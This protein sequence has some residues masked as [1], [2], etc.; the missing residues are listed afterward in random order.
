MPAVDYERL[1]GLY[2]ALVATDADTEFFVRRSLGAS[3]KVVELMAGTGRVALPVA[4]AGVDLTCVDGSPAMLEILRRKLSDRRL[5]ARVV[6]QDVENLDLDSR[7]SLAFIAFNSFMEITEDAARERALRRIREHLV[8][9]GSFICTLHDP[10]VRLRS[11]GPD[12]PTR[13][14]LRDPATGREIEMS[15][16]TAVENG[17]SLVLGTERF[18]DAETGAVLL[19]LPLSFRITDREQFEALALRSGFE[20]DALYGDYVGGPYVAG[21]SPEM[22]WVLRRPGV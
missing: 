3:G 10:E 15:V 4:A 1:A 22:V 18:C 2:D 21:S 8:P 17:T 11:V 9:G 20:V 6:R 16:L 12:R 5:S 7:F 19:E 14:R 13:A